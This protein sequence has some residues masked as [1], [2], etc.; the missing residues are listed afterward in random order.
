MLAAIARHP[1]DLDAAVRAIAQE[2]LDRGSG[3]NLSVQVV[4][5]EQLPQAET[6]ELQRQAAHLPLPPLL[7]PRMLFDGYRVVRELH[8][9]SRSHVWLAVD[10]ESRQAVVLKTPSIDLQDDAA[11]RE[12]FL[13]EEWVARRVDSAHVLRGGAPTR[14]R[15]YLYQVMEYVEGRTLR[16]WMV[17]HP[18]PDVE[19]VRALVDQ[20]ARGLRALHR[21]EMVHQDLR[22]ENVMIDATGTARIID[23]GATHVAGIAE[24]APDGAAVPLG[25]AQY[26]A[27]E[28]ILGIAPAPRAD[29]FSLAVIAYEMLTGQLPYG[30]QVAQCRT[31]AQQRR[32]RYRSVQASRPE[33]AAWLDD[34]L[35]K[36]LQP[37]PHKRHGDVAEFVFN[38]HHPDPQHA[39]RRRLPLIERNPLVFWKGLSL[40]LALGWLV[41]LGWRTAGS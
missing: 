13:L 26:S 41:M 17:D 22:P 4:R 35:E 29:L 12:R 20:V 34:A 7:S 40:L 6:H 8:A 23:F 2:A 10:E 5:V 21:L 25:T 19:T 30:A 28:S 14:R 32:L 37:E 24:G 1:G 15:N 36:A 16:Q 18:R 33:L 9:S 3:D 38:L 31:L 27:P 11:Y 39:G